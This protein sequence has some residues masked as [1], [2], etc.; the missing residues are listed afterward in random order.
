MRMEGA[1]NV[2]PSVFAVTLCLQLEWR[3][4]LYI[5]QFQAFLIWQLPDYLLVFFLRCGV[6]LSPHMSCTYLLLPNNMYKFS[7]LASDLVFQWI[8][9]LTWCLAVGIWVAYCLCYFLAHTASGLL[10]SSCIIT[11]FLNKI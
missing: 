11:F 10:F 4:L 6:I 8:L 9:A 2:F 1:L 5:E 3:F 7:S